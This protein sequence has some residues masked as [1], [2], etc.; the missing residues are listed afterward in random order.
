MDN[1]QLFAYNTFIIYTN[2][3]TDNIKIQDI[4]G[5]PVGFGRIWY[6]Q[7]GEYYVKGYEE[8]GH[9]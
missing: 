2:I 6:L 4:L 1:K 5:Y 9:R 8:K 3:N 7:K